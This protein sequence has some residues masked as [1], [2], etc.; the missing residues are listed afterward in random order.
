V[1]T[2]KTPERIEIVERIIR[3]ARLKPLFLAAKVT[4]PDDRDNVYYSIHDSRA[5]GIIDFLDYLDRRRRKKVPR[6]DPTV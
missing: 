4:Y 2:G 1:G 5:S 3:V 6:C